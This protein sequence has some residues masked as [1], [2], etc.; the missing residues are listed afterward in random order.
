M[1][2]AERMGCEVVTFGCPRVYTKWGTTPVLNH[3]RIIRDEDPVPM[4]PRILFKHDCEPVVL[5]DS[6]DET[7]EVKDHFIDG[8]IKCLKSRKGEGNAC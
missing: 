3:I 2:L 6:D 1:L 4:I 8:Y 5:Y 7:I